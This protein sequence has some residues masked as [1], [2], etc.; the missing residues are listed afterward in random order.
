MKRL[1][2]HFNWVSVSL[3]V[4]LALAWLCLIPPFPGRANG[5]GRA[6]P[7]LI[8]SAKP[9]LPPQS[10]PVVKAPAKGPVST[11]N[12]QTYGDFGGGKT[13]QMSPPSLTGGAGKTN[14]KLTP[15]EQ[16]KEKHPQPAHPQSRFGD[17]GSR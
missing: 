13:P 4:A 12:R 9:G 17:Y 1:S 8:L 5:T 11:Q 16:E 2:K 6:H 15:A 7:P 3:M 10:G 14:R